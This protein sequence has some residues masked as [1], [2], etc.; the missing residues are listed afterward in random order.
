MDSQFINDT[1]IEIN[2]ITESIQMLKNEETIFNEFIISK[3][4]FEII[5]RLSLTKPYGDDGT[6]NVALK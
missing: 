6:P 5:K 1:G 3:D 2:K 4:V